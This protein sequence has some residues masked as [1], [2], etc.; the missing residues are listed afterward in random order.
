MCE[1][2][3]AEAIYALKCHISDIKYHKEP[4]LSDETITRLELA[5]DALTSQRDKLLGVAQDQINLLKRLRAS[6]MLTGLT[7]AANAGAWCGWINDA[8]DNFTH[9]RTAIENATPA[10]SAAESKG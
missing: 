3:Y 7:P 5:I 6:D 1:A 8:V 9:L 4:D 10:A 2:K